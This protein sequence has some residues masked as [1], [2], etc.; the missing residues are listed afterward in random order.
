MAHGECISALHI[1]QTTSWT[2]SE[3]KDLPTAAQ[4]QSGA[5]AQ[6]ADAAKSAA[7]VNTQSQDALQLTMRAGSAAAAEAVQQQEEEPTQSVAAL[8]QQPDAMQQRTDAMQQGTDA[9]LLQTED[10]LQ[11]T[12]EM[13]RTAGMQEELQQQ[14]RQHDQK[15]V[16][17]GAVAPD[18]STGVLRVYILVST[19]DRRLQWNPCKGRIL[20]LQLSNSEPGMCASEA[21]T[22]RP[23]GPLVCFPQTYAC[24]LQL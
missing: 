17:A 23:A 20:L 15:P 8:Q 22:S 18:E 5:G 2:Q 12:E 7:H 24:W 1:W 13:Q 4:L 3:P 6:P 19:K 9:M 11:G 14:Q 21:Q 10:M 16:Q